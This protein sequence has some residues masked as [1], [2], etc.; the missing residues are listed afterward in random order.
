MDV[1]KESETMLEWAAEQP[2][3]ITRTAIDLEFLPMDTNVD[4]GVRYLEF[5]LQQMHTA[6]MAHEL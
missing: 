1:I 3:E 6:L 2:T 5:V 4:S